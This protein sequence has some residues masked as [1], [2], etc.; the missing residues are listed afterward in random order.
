MALKTGMF[1]S[2]ELVTSASGYAVGNK[3]VSAEFFAR[4][5][6]SFVGSG[7]LK[8]DGDCFKVVSGDGMKVK[9]LPGSAFL[10]GYFCYDDSNAEF[11]VSA[12]KT[13][14]VII[15]LDTE[16]GEIN[17]NCTEQQG[18]ALTPVR[19]GSKYELILAK[20]TIPLGALSVADS[21]ITDLR[22]ND[23]YCGYAKSKAEMFG[24]VEYATR[25]G[26]VDNID[27][28]IM[29]GSTKPVSGGAV[30]NA[31][32]G[33]QGKISVGKYKG[34]GAAR[35]ISLGI[36]PRIVIIKSMPDSKVC[37]I[38]VSSSAPA[39][40]AEGTAIA[41]ISDNKIILHGSITNQTNT[42]YSYIAIP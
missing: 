6:S 5:F 8:G 29:S 39:Y 36:V 40:D 20:V 15:S 28:S 1:D 27:T 38:V 2:T 13:Y 19:Q 34:E 18:A 42:E 23:D 11:T 7:V 10:C 22:E 16:N 25:A 17:I 9:V 21:Y 33:K 31:V 24:S 37:D 32:S 35:I 41:K 14:N 26:S 3:A 12:G 30:Y 4:Y